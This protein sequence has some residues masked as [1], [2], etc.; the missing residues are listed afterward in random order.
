MEAEAPKKPSE[1]MV[2]ETELP[3]FKPKNTIAAG[4]LIPKKRKLV[5]TMILESLVDSV[6]T[7][8]RN[9]CRERHPKMGG[10]DLDPPKPTADKNNEKKIFPFQP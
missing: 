9:C 1:K 4:S 2:R 3:I 7:L 6:A 10:G 5:K 8:L